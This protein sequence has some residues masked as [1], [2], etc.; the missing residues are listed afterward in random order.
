MSMLSKYCYK[1]FR[2]I[3]RG[4]L[5][6]YLFLT[7]AFERARRIASDNMTLVAGSSYAQYAF[8]SKLINDSLLLAG[9]SQDV[10]YSVMC[11]KRAIDLIKN[12]GGSVKKCILILGY[13]APFQDLSLQKYDRTKH[14]GGTYYPLFND[15]HNWDNPEDTRCWHKGYRYPQWFK[16]LI[17]NQVEN[18]LFDTNSYFDDISLREK[19]RKGELCWSQLD[20]VTRRRIAQERADKHNRLLKYTGVF[21]NTLRELENLNSCL[22]HNGIRLQVVVPPFSREYLEFLSNDMKEYFYQWLQKIDL[23][24]DLMDYNI[25]DY[26]FLD[27][28]YFIDPD[29]LSDTGA[30]LFTKMIKEMI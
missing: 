23:M 4:G 16:D 22:N 17:E 18:Y 20:E 27:D 28:C 2:G 10:Y 29:H 25:S 26:I 9:P 11:L 8:D 13:Y 5:L 15:A 21:N 24:N 3:L 12:N 30:M 14:L 6:E 1:R 19:I 7:A